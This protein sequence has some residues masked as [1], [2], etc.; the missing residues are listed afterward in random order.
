MTP[1]SYLYFKIKHAFKAASTEEGRRYLAMKGLF[2]IPTTAEGKHALS[3]LAGPSIYMID[4]RGNIIGTTIPPKEPKIMRTPIW[5]GEQPLSFTR[6]DRVFPIY[7]SSDQQGINEAFER[8]GTFQVKFKFD[9][10]PD[11]IKTFF[12]PHDARGSDMR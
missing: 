4:K 3:S 7:D 2:P 1:R 11:D 5:D 12:T 6:D 8:T 9:P 10:L